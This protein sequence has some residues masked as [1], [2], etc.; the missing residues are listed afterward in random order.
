MREQY[1]KS[2]K[3]D[4]PF[5][6]G[7]STSAYQ[8]EGAATADG[9]GP[10]IWDTYCRQKGK[11]AN[12]DTGDIACDHYHRYVEDVA[13]LRDLGV[14]AYR[15]S[16]SWPRLLPRGRGKLNP[17]GATFYDRLIDELLAA[18]IDPWICLYHWDLPQAL[19]DEG[20][21]PHRDSVGWFADYATLVG[22]RYG[23]RVKRFATFNEP[24]V[25]SLFGYAFGWQAPGL[26][27]RQAF[28]R[29]VHH[30]NLAHGAAVD[31]LRGAVRD[32]K[33][34]VIHNLQ[35]CHAAS[36]KPEDQAAAATLD[37]YWNRAFPD[38][39]MLGY[40]PERLADE[41][42]PYTL[43]GDLAAMSRPIDWFGLNHYSPIYARADQTG[44]LGFA[45][46]GPP[47]DLPHSG[48]GWHVQP[49]AFRDTLIAV[50]E[51]YRLPVYVT[52]NGTGGKDAPDA[53]G[54]VADGDRIAY[55][56]AYIGAMQEARARGADIRGYFVWSLLDNFEWGSG[57]RDRFGLVYVD[58]STLRRI[59]K[60]SYHWYAAHIASDAAARATDPHTP[61]KP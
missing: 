50:S 11:I 51:R 57:Y 35:P 32:A 23:D 30:V 20:G 15:F 27:D 46:A 34:G 45:W 5:V 7:A 19:D 42:A 25:F 13:L 48:V 61:P 58:Y 26:T 37:L 24:G 31:A 14:N 43:P 33:I 17:L 47:P 38:P 28:L 8:I 60:D 4:E 16:I 2:A 36:D 1:R 29:S 6:W 59:P 52:E 39:Q 49:E 22:H 56:D 55:L 21:W 10:S 54:R 9:R 44:V 12:G 3:S 41:L 18:G 40:Y 53:Q